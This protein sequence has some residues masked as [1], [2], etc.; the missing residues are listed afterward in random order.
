M[1][2]DTPFLVDIGTGLTPVDPDDPR[3]PDPDLGA[4]VYREMHPHDHGMVRRLP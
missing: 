2:E 3:L 1:D 4:R